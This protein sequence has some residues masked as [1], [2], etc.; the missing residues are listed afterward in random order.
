MISSIDKI[1][2]LARAGAAEDAGKTSQA[3]GLLGSFGSI[4]RSAIDN[5][6]TT[7]QEKTNL[8]YQLSVG[9]LDNPALLVIASSKYQVAVDLLVQLRNKALEAYSELTRISL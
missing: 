1:M 4:F 6:I 5:V 8:E 9:E 2:P 3:D 7:D